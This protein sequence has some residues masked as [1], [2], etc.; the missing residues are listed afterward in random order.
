[1]TPLYL[2]RI[3]VRE[4]RSSGRLTIDLP[5]GPGVLISH[6]PNGLGK[7]SLFDGLE[8]A[9]TDKVDHFRDAK[10]APKQHY[11]RNWEAP[12]DKPTLIRLD[13]GEDR[14]QRSLFGGLDPEGVTDIVQF[15]KAPA[16]QNPIRHLDR[17]LLLTHFLGQS[18]VS[19]M[20]HRDAK[21]RWEFLQ[22][23]AQS[24][25]AIDIVKALHG[26]GASTPAK[27]FE[28]RSMELADQAATLERLLRREEEQWKEAQLEGAIDDRTAA[29]EATA[30]NAVFDALLAEL[31]DPPTGSMISGT[32]ATDSLI[33]RQDQVSEALRVRGQHLARAQAMI[34]DRDSAAVALA[35]LEGSLAAQRQQ[36]AEAAPILER[37]RS[38]VEAALSTVADTV[39]VQEAEA[40]AT[41]LI[42]DFE[43]ARA[44]ATRTASESKAAKVQLLGRG[45]RAVE[46]R[47][48]QDWSPAAQAERSRP[49]TDQ[50]QA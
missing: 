33:A 25:R 26:H 43:R 19:R 27:T 10:R 16:W 36:A 45:R 6:G 15:L 21:E 40:A 39:A 28:R 42:Q 48:S 7:S 46:T 22:G 35:G 49:P 41:A 8:W 38:A 5:N 30:I 24:D 20:T 44:D 14:I 9:L 13:F 37:A 32:T 18:T 31:Q 3:D 47:V 23:P 4:F 12:A 17:Y 50:A 34:V 1:M 2:T 29:I 11:L